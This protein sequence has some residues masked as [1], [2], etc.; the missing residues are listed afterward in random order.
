MKMLLQREAA[1]GPASSRK[2]ILQRVTMVEYQPRMN[3]LSHKAQSKIKHSSNHQS[4]LVSE[5]KP[6]YELEKNLSS[7]E[8]LR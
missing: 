5:G 8:N 2:Q 7:D 1:Y 3:N 6:R 4:A